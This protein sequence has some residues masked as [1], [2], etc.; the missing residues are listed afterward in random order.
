MSTKLEK[1]YSQAV[2]NSKGIHLICIAATI[3][4]HSINNNGG[5]IPHARLSPNFPL[6][7]VSEQKKRNAGR[8]YRSSNDCGVSIAAWKGPQGTED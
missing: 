6:E 3:T 7:N 5:E 4:V 1:S 2:V 8:L